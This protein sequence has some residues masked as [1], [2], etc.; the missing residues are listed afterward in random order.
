[1]PLHGV[2]DALIASSTSQFFPM[3]N[4]QNLQHHILHDTSV[5]PQKSHTSMHESPFWSG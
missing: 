5:K 3:A 1:M 2:Y 4:L